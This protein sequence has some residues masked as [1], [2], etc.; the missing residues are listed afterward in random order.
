MKRLLTHYGLAIAAIACLAAVEPSAI[1]AADE[2][3]AVGQSSEK[4]HR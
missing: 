4:N 3:M 1:L 2:P